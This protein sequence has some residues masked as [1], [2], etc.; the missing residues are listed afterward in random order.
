MGWLFI[1]ILSAFLFPLPLFLSVEHCFVKF[2]CSQ[3]GKDSWEG[4][5][6]KDGC[7]MAVGEGEQ[8]QNGGDRL[9]GQASPLST[10]AGLAKFFPGFSLEISDVF[11][12]TLRNERFLNCPLVAARKVAFITAFTARQGSI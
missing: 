9:V 10:Q 11:V 4:K 8:R 6:G 12:R 5:Q 2:L 1:V 3:V 7:G